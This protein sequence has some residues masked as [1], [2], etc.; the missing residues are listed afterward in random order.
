[1]EEDLTPL[2]RRV[3]ELIKKSGD[4][5]T[6]NVPPE[7]RGAVPRLVDKG[8]VEVYKRPTSPWSPKKR[9]FLRSR[10]QESQMSKAC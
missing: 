10:M 3:Y 7:M 9:K 4:I 6:T 5:L 8:L 1:V 2:E